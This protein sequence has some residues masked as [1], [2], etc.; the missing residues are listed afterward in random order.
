MKSEIFYLDASGVI[1]S[2][3]NQNKNLSHTNLC[4]LQNATCGDGGYAER[5][6]VK[7]SPNGEILE[8]ERLKHTNTQ[9]STIGKMKKRTSIQLYVSERSHK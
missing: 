7:T 6:P 1:K 2:V 4:N 8:S 3:D 9:S 5:P